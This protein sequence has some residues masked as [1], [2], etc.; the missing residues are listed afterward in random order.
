MNHI[1][2]NRKRFKLFFR[3]SNWFTG[4]RKLW[5][6]GRIIVYDMQTRSCC[7]GLGRSVKSRTV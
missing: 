3:I 2:K 7:F 5:F 1:K 6:R 4:N